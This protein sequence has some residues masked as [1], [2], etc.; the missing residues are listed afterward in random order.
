MALFGRKSRWA[1]VDM[2]DLIPA[3]L[4]EHVMDQESQ[5]VVLK[6]PRFREPLVG[7][8]IQRMIPQER[9]YLSVPLESKGSHIWQ[10]IDGRRPVRELA[11]EIRVNFPEDTDNIHERVSIYMVGLYQ[12]K[13]IEFINL[14]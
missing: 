4:V 9:K 11:E 5:R 3:R 14:T 13:F 7:K 1:G 2:L 8:W 12:N 10:A 6:V